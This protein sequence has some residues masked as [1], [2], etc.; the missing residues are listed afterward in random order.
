MKSEAYGYFFEIVWENGMLY[1]ET[2]WAPN[3]AILVFI[4]DEYGVGFNHIYDEV[5]NGVF[6]EASYMDGELKIIGLDADDIGQYE[7]DGDSGTYRFENLT[8][9]SSEDILQLMLERKKAA[10]R[11]QDLDPGSSDSL[12]NE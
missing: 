4:A 12:E 11:Q 5:G 2:K 6:G 1:Y 7:Y 9:A 10:I 8:Y 3:T